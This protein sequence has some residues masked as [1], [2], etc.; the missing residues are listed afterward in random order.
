MD[1]SGYSAEYKDTD[2]YTSDIDHDNLYNSYNILS[3]NEEL[4]LFNHANDIL[5]MYDFNVTSV[6]SG[7]FFLIF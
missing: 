4:F 7:L 6:K 5:D 3:N 2:H 1:Y